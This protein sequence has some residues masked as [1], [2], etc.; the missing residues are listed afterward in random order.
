M[1]NEYEPTTWLDDS[2]D[3]TND[4]QDTDKEED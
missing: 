1:S 4:Q 3:M 2:L